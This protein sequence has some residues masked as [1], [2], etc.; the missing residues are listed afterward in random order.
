MSKKWVWAVIVIVV[1]AV[2]AWYYMSHKEI[3]MTDAKE[4]A[5]VGNAMPSSTSV[6]PTDTAAIDAQVTAMSA[7]VSALS[8]TSSPKDVAA[9]AAM[10]DSTT[11]LMSK[12][13]PK[14][15]AMI[16]TA[17]NAKKDVAALQAAMKDLGTQVASAGSISKSVS[18][19]ANNA[20]KPMDAAGVAA[21]EAQLSTAVSYIVKAQNDIHTVAAGLSALK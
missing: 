18:N 9:A 2:G 3:G 16:S 11:V 13:A 1:V 19:N 21:A 17:Q 5:A 8:K 12:V 14:L 10:I 15:Q 20:K 6:L 4:T 7:A